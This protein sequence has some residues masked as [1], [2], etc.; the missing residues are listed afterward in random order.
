MVF[1]LEDL[2]VDDANLRLLG[3]A[4]MVVDSA[5]EMVLLL[6]GGKETASVLCVRACVRACV[7][8]CLVTATFS[9]VF[10]EHGVLLQDIA[11]QH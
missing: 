2:V 8:V 5:G 1:K 3:P 4:C 11:K 6:V 9:P 10:L 7:C